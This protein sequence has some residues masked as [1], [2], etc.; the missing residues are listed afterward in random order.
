MDFMKMI[1]DWQRIVA[2]SVLAFHVLCF[3]LGLVIMLGVISVPY[4]SDT[5]P[6]GGALSGAV[7]TGILC[8]LGICAFG[9]GVRYAS[10]ATLN[11]CRAVVS[12]RITPA[13]TMALSHR[14]MSRRRCPNAP[15]VRSDDD[16]IDQAADQMLTNPATF[17]DLFRSA[18]RATMYAPR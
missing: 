2:R 18:T 9:G 1:A 17:M 8:L 13:T 12:A 10:T 14:P 3:A 15:S 11:C 6:T 7:V 5:A 4:L 16:M